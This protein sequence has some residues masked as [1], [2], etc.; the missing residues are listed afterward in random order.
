MKIL[1][2]I[3]TLEGGGAERQLCYLAR[4]LVQAENAVRVVCIRGGVNEPRLRTATSMVDVFADLPPAS[5]RVFWRLLRTIRQFRPDLIQ[6]WICQMD[7]WGG[8]AARCAGIPWVLSERCSAK[9][10]P[11]TVK[12]RLRLG[13]GRG[14]SLVVAN[15]RAGAAYWQ[16][17]FGGCAPPIRV[18]SNAL[19]LDEIAAVAAARPC[20]IN[21]NERIILYAGRLDAQKNL[22][23]FFRALPEVLKEGRFQIL[24]CGDGPEAETLRKMAAEMG[25]AARIHFLGYVANLYSLMKAAD[26]FVSVSRFEG[27]PN[28]V[29]EAMACGCPLVVSDIPEHREFLDERSAF[30]APVGASDQ[31]AAQLRDCLAAPE[32]ARAKAKVARRIA[33][34]WDIGATARGY[35][36]A[37]ARCAGAA[38]G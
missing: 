32:V 29:M 2:C 26:V 3:P 28:A 11:P 33:E 38:G 19:P 18:I 7:V 35:L 24:I 6:T 1:Q 17:R 5:P 20:G 23:V 10:Y 30:L 25:L 15:S 21:A 34:Q 16:E 31:L 14:A 8:I 27:Q 22:P 36:A 37:Y 9:M 13:V 12:N 4:G